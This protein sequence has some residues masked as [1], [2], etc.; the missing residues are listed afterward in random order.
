MAFPRSADD[1]NR[2]QQDMHKPDLSMDRARSIDTLAPG[3]LPRF[4]RV[5][6]MTPR[7]IAETFGDPE[8]TAWLIR[9]M[10]R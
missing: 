5:D 9:S 7:E 2:R 4:L 8:N 3:P 6:K 1:G 10:G